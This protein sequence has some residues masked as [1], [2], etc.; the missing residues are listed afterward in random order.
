MTKLI[1]AEKKIKTALIDLLQHKPFHKIT[2]TDIVKAAHINRSTYYYH[3][4]EIDEVLDDVIKKAIEDLVVKMMDSIRD[5]NTYTIDNNVLPSTTV[6]FEHI[7][8]YRKYYETLLNSDVSHRFSRKFVTAITHF[9][10]KLD[11]SF[12]STEGVFINR[13]MYANFYA[14]ATFGQVQFW[15]DHQFEYSTEYMAEQLTNFMLTK[16]KRIVPI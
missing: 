7:Y 12:N 13:Q 14:N 11:I 3:Y 5:K 4:Y 6:M 9:N 10:L 15:I 2:V 8:T 1:P 16:A